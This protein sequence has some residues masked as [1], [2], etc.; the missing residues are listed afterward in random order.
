[1]DR[2]GRCSWLRGLSFWKKLSFSE[3]SPLLT[4]LPH[5]RLPS[6]G[7]ASYLAACWRQHR[8]RIQSPKQ[9]SAILLTL[10]KHRLENP[11]SPTHTPP[12]HNPFHTPSSTLHPISSQ[13]RQASASGQFLCTVNETSS[14]KLQVALLL[15]LLLL[16]RFSHVP[17]CATPETAAHE[18]PPS[19][20]FSRQE[21]WSGLP[22]TSP[23][24]E[25]EK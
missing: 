6:L 1:M 12:P 14:G 18:A 22:F 23:M 5:T 16:S 25:S 8:C 10:H 20:G 17:L 13:T 4:P 2:A 24:H 21:H 11:P 15:L 9:T 19:L 7:C 3:E